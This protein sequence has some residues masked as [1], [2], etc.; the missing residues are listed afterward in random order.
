VAPPIDVHA[1]V[2]VPELLRDAAPDELWRPAVNRGQ[3]EF[4]GR[5]VGS[6]VHDCVEVDEILAAES[7]LGIGGVLV[8][9]WVPLLLYDVDADEGLSR[10]RLQNEGLARLRGERVSVLGAVPLQA[11]RVMLGS[12]YPF[13][14]ADP[15]PVG[16][17][18]AAG[19]TSDAEQAVLAGN[20]R[21]ELR[22]GG[23]G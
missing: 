4:G 21:R 6:I 19:L 17:V 9:P 3:V 1:H 2:I 22:L 5:R 18:R 12:D 11:P 10:C 13:D 14:M 8:S 7:R 16:T 23:D 20:A 15:D